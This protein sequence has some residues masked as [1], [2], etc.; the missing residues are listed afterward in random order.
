[1]IRLVGGRAW[2]AATHAARG[3]PAT[4]LGGASLMANIRFARA[5]GWTSRRL[6]RQLSAPRLYLVRGAPGP[7]ASA[8]RRSPLR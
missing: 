5:I 7:L 8:A 4:P 6:V 3:A 2:T 1:M